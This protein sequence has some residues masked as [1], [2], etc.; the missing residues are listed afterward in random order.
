MIV[1]PAIDLRGGRCVRLVQGRFD[2]ETV[3]SDDPVAVAK[4]WEAA[5]AQLIHVVDLDGARKGVPQHLEVIGR[6][7]QAVS[8]PV[9][10]GG[11]LR[12]RWVIE[13]ALDL[14]VHRVVVG[15]VAALDEEG[16]WRLIRR[17]DTQLVIGIDAREGKVAVR[18]WEQVTE[19]TA[20]DLAKAMADFGARRVVYTDISRDGMLAG[21]NL[22]AVRE[23]VAST[24]MQVI[25]SGGISSREDL[26]ALAELGVEGAIVGKA[27]YTGALPPEAVGE[28]A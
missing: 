25:A 8:V 19:R 1:I 9:Q 10:L 16:A 26:A 20:V 17:F 27:L 2:D 6:I 14:G 11:G 5:G 12:D 18:G 4:R 21:V 28:F 23:F 3:F 15:T 7:C 13:Q 22:E 24:C